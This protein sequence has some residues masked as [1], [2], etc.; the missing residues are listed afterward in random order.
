MLMTI[1]SGKIIYDIVLISDIGVDNNDGKALDYIDTE[2]DDEAD[3]PT[4]APN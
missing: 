2:K 1:R 3:R 4:I